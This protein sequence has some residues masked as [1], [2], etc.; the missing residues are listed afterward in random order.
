MS[1]NW[2]SW[3]VNQKIKAKMQQA[4]YITTINSKE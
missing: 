1:I 2:G 3:R 4:N